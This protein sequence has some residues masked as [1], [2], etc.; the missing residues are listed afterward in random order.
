M[1]WRS[2]LLSAGFVA[3][4]ALVWELSPYAMDWAGLG[5]FDPL[6]RI[7]LIIVLLSVAEY[8]LTR[9]QAQH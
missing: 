7:C 6:D 4:A 1:N 2:G 5:A 3:M 9:L 8:G